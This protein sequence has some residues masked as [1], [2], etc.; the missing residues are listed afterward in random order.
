MNGKS[1]LVCQMGKKAIGTETIMAA[2]IEVKRGVRPVFTV[3]LIQQD[4][5]SGTAKL[6]SKVRD[7]Y[8]LLTGPEEIQIAIQDFA[9][10]LKIKIDWPATV[11]VL[12]DLDW[13]TAAL[14][15]INTGQ[16]TPRLPVLEN[17]AAQRSLRSFGKVTV[18]VMWGY[19]MHE[20]S[21]S[22]AQ[23]LRIVS[24]EPWAKEKQ[25]AYEGERFTGVW[26][27]DGNHQ[28]VISYDDGG[29]AWIGGLDDLD[30]V[31]GPLVESV[32]LALLVLAASKKAQQT[33]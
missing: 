1:I 10:R 30:F 29:E 5:P 31:K 12:S 13:M 27:F 20:L 33:Q 32:D 16:K 8:S 17:L 26:T 9:H 15:A 6:P 24:G 19:D 23:W 3:S 2:V 28:L 25:F 22:Y 14:I 11:A 7:K 18:G 4:N 21:M